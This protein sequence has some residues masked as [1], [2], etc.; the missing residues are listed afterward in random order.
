MF[1]VQVKSLKVVLWL[2][3]FL[4]TNATR[5]ACLSPQKRVLFLINNFTGTFGVAYPPA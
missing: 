4:T 5:L 3:H 2:W 1:S